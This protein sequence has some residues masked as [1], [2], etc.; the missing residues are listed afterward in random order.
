MRL[1]VLWP[2]RVRRALRVALAGACCVVPAAEVHSQ[3]D[4]PAPA[5]AHSVPEIVVTAPTPKKRRRSA[6]RPAASSTQ[7]SQP[8]SIP[9]N[10]TPAAGGLQ[11][12]P[13]L[14]KT[15]TALADLPQS[16]VIVPSSLIFEQGSSKVAD[17]VH[18]VSGV[19]IGGTST[20]GFFD[21]FTIRGLDARIY[22]DGFP[23]G[24]QSNGL[25]HS[26]N[27]VQSV[28]VLKGPGSAL[29]GS[30]T[31][32]GIINIVHFL[33]S[34]VP[35][36]GMS[37]Q[38]GSFGSWFNNFY[39]T[40]PT[41]VPGVDYRFDGLLQHADGFRGL[42]S[43]NYE[44]RPAVSWNHDNHVTTFAVDARD[45]QRTPD[46]YGIVYFNG[47]PLTVV[48]NTAKYSTPFSFGNQDVERAT[49]ANSWWYADYVTIN[50]RFSFL[51]R[52]VDI[53]RNSGGTVSGT[54]LTSRQLREQ[55]DNDNDLFYQ[56]EPVWK[57]YSGFVHHT[58]LTGAQAEWDS[59]DDNRATADLPNISNIFAPVIPETS[60]TGLNFLRDAKHS[61]MVDDLRA[62]F[63]GVYATDQI[64][65]TDQWK[66]DTSIKELFVRERG[67]SMVF[68][69]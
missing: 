36:Y 2:G 1:L 57:F 37:A 25:P 45:I 65:V 68:G 9:G 22:T 59:I 62:W 40:G 16:V 39:A 24:D 42:E 61:G 63:L 38:A 47:P 10:A 6:A 8:A 67:L 66:V 4:G 31:P 56:F 54:M 41:T 53:V 60:T 19:N 20:Y 35:A 50:D 43:A 13:G 30:A 48:P 14:G 46:S 55:I 52:D 11:Q 5:Q 17:I 28:E 34:P 18:D 51:H 64:D 21:R 12:A 23:D 32:G 26:L 7:E 49:I 33:P 29:F 58:L 15:G 44:F 3:A 69:C 27:G